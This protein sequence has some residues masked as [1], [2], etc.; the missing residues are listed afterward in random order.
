MSTT[1]RR[2]FLRGKPLG[3]GGNAA[4]NIEIVSLVVNAFPQHLEEVA[5]EVAALPGTDVHITDQKGKLIVV[6][7]ASTQGEIGSVAN[8]ISGIRHVLSAAMV[9]QATE[10]LAV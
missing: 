10:N 6:L 1:T 9:F 8:A 4:G 3:H 2:N 7:E 5:R